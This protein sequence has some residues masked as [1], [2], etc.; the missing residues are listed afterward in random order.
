MWQHTASK[1]LEVSISG[2]LPT[3]ILLFQLLSDGRPARAARDE[4]GWPGTDELIF[5]T[6]VTREVMSRRDGR[7]TPNTTHF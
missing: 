1:S 6:S 3:S 4:A 7:H 5:D 2:K